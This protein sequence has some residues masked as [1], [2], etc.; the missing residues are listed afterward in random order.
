MRDRVSVPLPV[1]GDKTPGVAISD[2]YK[3][4]ALL[5]DVRPD[6]GGTD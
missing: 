2:F 3:G 5:A 1:A 6:A 4:P